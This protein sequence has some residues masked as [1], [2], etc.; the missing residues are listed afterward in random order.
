MFGGFFNKNGI[1]DPLE[2]I[3][4]PYLTTLNFKSLDP[5]ILLAAVNNLSEH[6]LVAPY[7]FIGAAALSVLRAVTLFIFVSKEACIMFW[8]PKILVFINLLDYI[9]QLALV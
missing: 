6:N 1:T 9:L 2:P 3:T 5:T 8:A 7:K 4:F